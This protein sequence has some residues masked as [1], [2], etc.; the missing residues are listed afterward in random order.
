MDRIQLVREGYDRLVES[1]LEAR[2][3]YDTSGW[4]DRMTHRLPENA[5][6]LDL[7][8]GAGVPIARTLVSQGYEVTGID[9]SAKQVQ[10]AK[11]LVPEATFHVG[12]MTEATFP[13][14]SFDGI[15]AFYSII[16]VPRER[17]ANLFR[18]IRRWLKQGGVALLVLGA[19]DL[20]DDEEYMDGVPMFWSHFAVETNRRLLSD[21]G[22][23]VIEEGIVP[24]PPGEHWFIL[25]E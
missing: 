6:I 2:E 15:C 16:H 23:R 5:R 25:V 22:L 24:D 3:Q 13:D 18:S 17:H 11:E 8:C 7:G 1:Y 14:E 9:G 21:A 20:E 12:D 4:L 19:H 10:K